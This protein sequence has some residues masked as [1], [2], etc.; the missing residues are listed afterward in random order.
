MQ[1]LNSFTERVMLPERRY[2]TD[3][4]PSRR[5]VPKYVLRS[6]ISITVKTR[7]KRRIRA[8]VA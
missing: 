4:E 1:F 8:A 7:R 5:E 3:E 2:F 6:Q